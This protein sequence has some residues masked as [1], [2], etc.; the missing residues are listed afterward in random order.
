MAVPQNKVTKS[1]RN[2]RRSHDSLVADNPNECPSCGELK[3]PHHVCPSCGHYA[4]REVV[5][6]AD[7]VDFDDE[8]AA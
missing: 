5:A 2:M 7:D 1:R 4:D 3:R 8:D 6:M